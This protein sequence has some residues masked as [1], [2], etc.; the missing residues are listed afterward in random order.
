MFKDRFKELC[1]NSGLTNEEIGDILG[2]SGPTV[3]KYKNGQREPAFQILCRIADH[4]GVTTEYLL[5][6]TEV[7][8]FDNFLTAESLKNSFREH[9]AAGIIVDKIFSIV[10]DKDNFDKLDSLQLI[11]H[12]IKELIKK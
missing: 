5:G 11:I 9:P 3:S 4:F 12:G 6:R 10:S 8:T 1:N 7:K 2:V